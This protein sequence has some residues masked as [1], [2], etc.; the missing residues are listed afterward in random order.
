VEDDTH[1][2]TIKAT[3]AWDRAPNP[4]SIITRRGGSGYWAKLYMEFNEDPN[5]TN[6]NFKIIAYQTMPAQHMRNFLHQICSFLAMKTE[7]S[8]LTLAF[9]LNHYRGNLNQRRAF[10]DEF[11]SAVLDI[12]ISY[13]IKAQEVSFTLRPMSWTVHNRQVFAQAKRTMTR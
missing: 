6:Y 9:E 13:N 5:D 4:Q 1:N 7:L 11:I 10:A 3:P 2:V 12:F 8:T